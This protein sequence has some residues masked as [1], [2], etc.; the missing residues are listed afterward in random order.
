M[1]MSVLVAVQDL[2]EASLQRRV[3]LKRQIRY[4]KYKS[5]R[6]RLNKDSSKALVRQGSRGDHPC[7]TVEMKEDKK[8]QVPG[9]S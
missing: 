5:S 9:E 4:I 8:S 7:L 6:Y 3:M 2:E 1:A